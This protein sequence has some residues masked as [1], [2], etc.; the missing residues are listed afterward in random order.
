MT[1][2]KIRCSLAVMSL[3]LL[4]TAAFSQEAYKCK[5]NGSMVYLDRPCPGSQ[6]RSESMPDQSINPPVAMPADQ[7]RTAQQ[8]K[9]DKDNDY[10]RDRVKAR[11]NE[12][13]KDQAAEQIQFCE[14]EYSKINQQISQIAAA[15]PTGTPLNAASA[16]AMVIDQEYR[17]TQIAA[18]QAQANAKRSQCDAQQR[19]FERKYLK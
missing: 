19:E 17:Q 18:L 16:R 15:S 14:S 11:I 13:E 2:T 7:Q 1:I 6:R 12:R 5:V 10:I 4:S 8:A 9:W 3:V